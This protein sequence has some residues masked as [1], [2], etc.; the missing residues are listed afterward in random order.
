[1]TLL[2]KIQNNCRQATFLIEKKSLS[3]LTFRETV[4]LRIHLYGCS[5]CGL[6]GQQSAVINTMVK[7]LMRNSAQPNIKLDD[8]FKKELQERIERELNKL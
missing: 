1:M 8:N 4:E 5:F 2:S 7:E 3:R 6:F